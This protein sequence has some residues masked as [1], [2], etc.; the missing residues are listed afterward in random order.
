MF[1]SEKGFIEKYLKLRTALITTIRIW[2][3]RKINRLQK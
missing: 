2:G 1:V 3:F